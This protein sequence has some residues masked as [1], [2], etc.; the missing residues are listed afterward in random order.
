MT[1]HKQPTLRKREELPE[2]CHDRQDFECAVLTTV[3]DG[4]FLLLLT[5]PF[6]ILV[7]E[8]LGNLEF[9]YQY[10]CILDQIAELYDLV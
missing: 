10:D 4:T 2:R 3:W 5:T 9:F 8:V 7:V 1:I 6:M